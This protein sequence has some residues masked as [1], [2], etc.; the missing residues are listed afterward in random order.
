MYDESKVYFPT[1]MCEYN[2]LRE[3]CP[4]ATDCVFGSGSAF[5]LKKHIV[6][7]QPYKITQGR[8]VAVDLKQAFPPARVIKQ[9]PKIPQK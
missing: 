9:N 8:E 5:F 6:V 1:I 3:E 7:P 4:S 2:S